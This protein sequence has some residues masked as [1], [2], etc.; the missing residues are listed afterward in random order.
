MG[1]SPAVRDERE[2][3]QHMTL[4]AL[5]GARTAVAAPDVEG[6]LLMIEDLARRGQISEEERAEARR[7]VLT[8]PAPTATAPV[9]F[10]PFVPQGELIPRDPNYKPSTWPYY[11]GGG[12]I[13]LVVALIAYVAVASQ[14]R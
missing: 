5:A 14:H 11:L 10:E 8:Q 9:V 12:I 4:A 7:N 1:E 13:L 6:Q 3:K 2:R